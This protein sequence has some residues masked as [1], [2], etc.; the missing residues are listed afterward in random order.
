MLIKFP[1][2]KKFNY[3]YGTDQQDHLYS[4]SASD[5]IIAG[6][7]HDFLYSG[8]G[9]DYL[10]G[11]KGDDQY[12]IKD[13][14]DHAVEYANEGTDYVNSYVSYTLGANI[15]NSDSVGWPSHQRHGQRPRQPP[16]RQQRQQHP[17]GRRWSGLYRRQ[18]G[19]RHHVWRHR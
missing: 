1:P 17:Q 16:L 14:D 19:R 11:G 12:W 15:E 9:A 3:I 13:S 2:P 4:T 10:Y 5:I 18:Q 8:D 7:G 6:D